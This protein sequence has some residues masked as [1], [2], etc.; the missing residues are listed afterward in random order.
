MNYKNGR[1]GD[2]S[3]AYREIQSG[4]AGWER[5]RGSEVGHRGR[6]LGRAWYHRFWLKAGVRLTQIF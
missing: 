3:G 1:D 4:C 6:K 2:V 5:E